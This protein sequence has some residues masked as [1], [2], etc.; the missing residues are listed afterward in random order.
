M[1]KHMIIV[2]GC[3]LLL[4]FFGW[5][6]YEPYRQDRELK[7]TWLYTSWIEHTPAKMEAEYQEAFEKVELRIKGLGFDFDS[8]DPRRALTYGS[9]YAESIIWPTF[10]KLLEDQ[11]P[12]IRA[13]AISQ[14]PDYL[15]PDTYRGHFKSIG[16]NIEEIGET[17]LNLAENDSHPFVR[18]QAAHACMEMKIHNRD[19]YSRSEWKEVLKIYSQEVKA[20]E[21]FKDLE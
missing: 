13:A 4:I 10:H 12:F 6:A 18:S 9:K 2:L 19:A 16:D 5:Q 7:E 14:L 3:C 20:K 21:T 17:L 8:D 1:K 15:L 11:D